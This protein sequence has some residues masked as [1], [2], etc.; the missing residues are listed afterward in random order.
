[1]RALLPLVALQLMLPAPMPWLGQPSPAAWMPNAGPVV[2]GVQEDVFDR[3]EGFL[4]DF[5]LAPRGETCRIGYQ[6]LE[7]YCINLASAR[8]SAQVTQGRQQDDAMDQ[9][10]GFPVDYYVAQ[11]QPCREGFVLEQGFCLALA[12]GAYANSGPVED[13]IDREAGYPVD[14]YASSQSCREGYSSVGEYC[15]DADGAEPGVNTAAGTM[16]SRPG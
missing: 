3:R 5:Y 2:A 11:G 1:M 9:D 6:R 15:I 10:Q 16:G 4:L 12:R 14:F 7:G 13:T 8:S